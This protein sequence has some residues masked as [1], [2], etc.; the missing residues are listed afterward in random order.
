MAMTEE[1]AMADISRRVDALHA[2]RKSSENKKC[3]TD[4]EA[5][6]DVSAVVDAMHEIANS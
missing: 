2:L 1:E 6:A 4:E 3:E 5:L